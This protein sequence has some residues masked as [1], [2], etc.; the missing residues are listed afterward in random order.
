MT[1]GFLPAKSPFARIREVRGQMITTLQWQPEDFDL[2]SCRLEDV[3]AAGPEESAA[4]ITSVLQGR[5][6][7]ATDMVMANAAAALLAAERVDSLT[8]GVAI[9]RDA[10]QNGEALRVLQRLARYSQEPGFREK[11]P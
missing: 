5:P 3:L 1:K 2:P 9:A 10:I 11:T 4:R 8:E 7:P 6:G